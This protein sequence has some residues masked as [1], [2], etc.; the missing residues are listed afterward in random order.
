[1]SAFDADEVNV[2]L[3]LNNDL[4]L[5]EDKDTLANQDLC[6]VFINADAGEGYLYVD[7]QRG[8]RNDLFAQKGGD[9]LGKTVAK[10]CGNG[11]GKTVVVVHSVGAVIVENW[12]N[13][14]QALVYAHLPGQESG[15]ALVSVNIALYFGY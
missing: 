5:A 1:M 3:V 15:N 11:K 14:V 6:I 13:D 9:T 12:I 7:G 10:G 4:S 8:D 2:A